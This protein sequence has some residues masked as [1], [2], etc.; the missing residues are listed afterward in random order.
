MSCFPVSYLG[1]LVIIGVPSGLHASLIASLAAATI[2]SQSHAALGD[3]NLQPPL[4]ATGLVQL[5]GT[6]EAVGF[7]ERDVWCQ[8]VRNGMTTMDSAV[9]V[10]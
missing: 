10:Y 8:I 3:L 7:L 5:V 1:V 4:A 6:A 9:L 2:D